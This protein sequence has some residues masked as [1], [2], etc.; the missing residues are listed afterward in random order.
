MSLGTIDNRGILSLFYF[1]EH[2]KHLM[3]IP[4][5]P[6]NFQVLNPWTESHGILLVIINQESLLATRS[7]RLAPAMPILSFEDFL[8]KLLPGN[9][10]FFVVDIVLL[11]KDYFINFSENRNV[12][13]GLKVIDGH[14]KSVANAYVLS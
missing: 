1:I 4:I 9:F 12:I 14:V 6:H 10:V 7:E 8:V 2:L 5:S 3:H 11:Y 13:Q